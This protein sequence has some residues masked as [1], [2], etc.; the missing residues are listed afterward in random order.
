MLYRFFAP[1]LL[2]TALLLTGACRSTQKYIETG[3]YDSAVSL[4]VQKL[5]GRKK[6]K[7][8]YVHALEV[9]F[10]KAQT[11][12]L[13]TARQLELE[14]RPENWMRIHD[15]HLCIRD[16][17]RLVEPLLPLVSDKGYK[18]RFELVDI[19]QM[20]RQSRDK[21]AEYLY[22]KAEALIERGERGDKQAARDAYYT[23]N[24]LEDR[25]YRQYRDK[26][27]LKRKARDLGTSYI[28][29][30]VKNQATQILP[31]AF[32]SRLLAI[33]KRELDSEWKAFYFEAEPGVQYDYR[34][35][36]RVTRIDASPERVDERRYVDEKEIQDGWDYVL[37]KRGNVMKDT[38][39]N[40]IKVPRMVRIRAQVVEMHQTKAVR[41]SG[42]VEV[43]DDARNTL[44]DTRDLSTEVLFENYAATFMGDQRALSE[45]SRR[46]IGNRPL[47][48]P[49]TEDM[50][51]QA[52]E[53]LKPNLREALR[54][55]RSIL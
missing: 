22:N 9:A 18:A 40:D 17:Q 38:L 26:D 54:Q 45:D 21:A 16:R 35:I 52:A 27:Q 47:P 39:G 41:L 55:N 4:A 50:L 42:Y 48:F 23:L 15:I 33:G 8:E 24:K 37:D 29:F 30:E 28:L 53:R 44:L 12:D 5:Q 43:R 31:P 6:K 51:V 19:D 25:Y 32:E 13:H 3:D 1:A 49:V 34:A 36:F 2:L 10:R 14:A 11:Q 7:D 46:C 20:E